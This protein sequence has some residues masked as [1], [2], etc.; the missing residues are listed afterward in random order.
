[1]GCHSS[2]GVGTSPPLRKTECAPLR[3]TECGCALCADRTYTLRRKALWRNLG[4]IRDLVNLVE[5]F[6]PLACP[7]IPLSYVYGKRREFYRP[8][9][10]IE[11]AHSVWNYYS[12]QHKGVA[13]YLMIGETYKEA[14]WIDSMRLKLQILDLYFKPERHPNCLREFRSIVQNGK[15]LRPEEIGAVI[16]HFPFWAERLR[17][18]IQQSTHRMLE[19][20][21]FYPVVWIIFAFLLRS[22]TVPLHTKIQ[23]VEFM[24]SHSPFCASICQN[25]P[26]LA[27]EFAGALAAPSLERNQLFLDRIYPPLP[28]PVNIWQKM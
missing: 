25:W 13:L 21:G 14:V 18:Q 20:N 23:I 22:A 1:M 26:N 4:G 28:D 15:S 19:L 12:T 17:Q 7:H 3:K 16:N 8:K 24:C 5:S 27:K 2:S 11:F 10:R 9:P 6:I